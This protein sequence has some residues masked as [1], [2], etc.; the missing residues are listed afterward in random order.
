MRCDHC[1]HVRFD[2]E[3]DG[4][5]RVRIHGDP[6][7]GYIK[8]LEKA[9]IIGYGRYVFYANIVQHRMYSER[10]LEAIA[11]KLRELNENKS[12]D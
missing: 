4:I 1:T 3:K 8:R 12:T 11:K 10:H 9:N 6:G 5:I 7:R 2:E